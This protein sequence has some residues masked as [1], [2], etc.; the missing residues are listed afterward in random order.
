MNVMFEGRRIINEK[1]KFC[2]R[3]LMYKWDKAY[4]WDI[5]IDQSTRKH[6]SI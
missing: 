3:D 1:A 5:S 6:R 4:M 2:M